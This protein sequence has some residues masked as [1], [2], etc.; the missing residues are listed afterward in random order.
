MIDVEIRKLA[1]EPGDVLVIFVP[2]YMIPAERADLVKRVSDALS[3]PA[4][5]LILDGGK[6]LSVVQPAQLG[7]A[8][9]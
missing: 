2:E 3:V 7:R 8:G 5:L 6:T 9:K 4:K 1:I